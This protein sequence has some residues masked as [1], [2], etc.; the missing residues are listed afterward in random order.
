MAAANYNVAASGNGGMS[1]STT[2]TR[3]PPN[4]QVHIHIY[5]TP[6]KSKGGRKVWKDRARDVEHVVAHG[7]WDPGNPTAVSDEGVFVSQGSNSNTSSSEAFKQKLNKRLMN[8]PSTGG[9]P[10]WHTVD[11]PL[12]PIKAS[13]VRVIAKKHV[14]CK[15]PEVVVTPPKPGKTLKR[16][17]KN[18]KSK[19]NGSFKDV[20]P[21]PTP[22]AHCQPRPSH[23]SSVNPEG[24]VLDF[25]G[26]ADD[27]S[28]HVE[29]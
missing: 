23:P 3:L 9:T 11:G 5:E 25:S 17:M 8:S 16:W 14:I 7:H 12:T 2:T 18:R 4:V 22:V 27:L 28:L 21:T 6:P 26:A 1:N 19:S 20:T 15:S 10:S 13:A 29:A 24:K